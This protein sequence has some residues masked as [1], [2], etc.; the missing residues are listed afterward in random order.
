MWSG[1]WGWNFCN[2]PLPPPQ[3]NHHQS[4]R[5]EPRW[6]RRGFGP[7]EAGDPEADD[8]QAVIQQASLFCRAALGERADKRARRVQILGGKEVKLAPR[9]ASSLGYNLHAGVGFKARDRGGQERL[10]HYILRPPLAK[11]RLQRREDGSG[12]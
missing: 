6:A 3:P 11:D 8:A 2:A 9:C 4:Q 12:G 7:E 5:L 10:C 1:I